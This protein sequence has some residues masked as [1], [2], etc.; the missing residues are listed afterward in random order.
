MLYRRFMFGV[1]TSE[2][3]CVTPDSADPTRSSNPPTSDHFAQVASIFSRSYRSGSP[4]PS[5]IDKHAQP[6]L[7]RHAPAL[8]WGLSSRPK[9]FQVLHHIAD[10]RGADLFAEV[11]GQGT[12]PTGS[13]FAKYPSTT[14]ET[15]RA[16]GHSF[17][18]NCGVFCIVTI[19]DP[20]KTPGGK[21]QSGL[22]HCHRRYPQ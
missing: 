3:P 9:I 20:L 19:H 1:K 12:R 14:R 15:L 6:H 11:T 10:R 2:A 4:P 7:G 22:H 17:L 13:P 18:Y 16:S 21:G 5:T 8:I